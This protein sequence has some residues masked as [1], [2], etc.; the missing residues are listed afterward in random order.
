MPLDPQV[1]TLMD[2]MAALNAP[3]IHTLTPELVRMGI[4]MQLADETDEPESV[5]QVVNRTIPG[6]AGEIPVRIY[7]PAGSG[8]FPALVFF[9]GGG[10][11][12]CDLDTHDNLC[13]DLCNAVGCVVVSVDYRLAPEHKFPAA[14]EDCYAATQW[15]AENAVEIN[16]IAGKIAIGG[17]SAGGNLTAVV[18]QMARDQGG[19][20]FTLQLLIYPATDF[21]YDGPSIHE[22]GQDYFLTV[23]DM[24]WFMNHYLNSDT[25]KKNPLASPLQSANLRG[26]PTALVITA[27]YDPLR[28]EGEAYGKRLKEA[29]VPVTISRYN[30][31]IHGFLSLEPL[32]DKGKQ[33]REECAQALRVAFSTQ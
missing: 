12:I 19:P 31:V 18:A 20:S 24:N 33:A 2:Q 3:P 9:H 32:T 8:P 25:D 16:T 1:Q 21:T 23:D 14:P 22:N 11:V 28:D 5:A 15:V 27:E 10:W 13:R 4:K 6:P 7:T 29:G 26:L 17:D 30:G